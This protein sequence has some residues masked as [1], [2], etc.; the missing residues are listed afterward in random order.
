MHNFFPSL[1]TFPYVPNKT[2]IYIVAKFSLG[3]GDPIYHLVPSE[4]AYCH[5]ECSDE[6]LLLKDY[7]PSVCQHEHM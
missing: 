7:V 3:S 2:A 1:T 6:L 4:C 5:C